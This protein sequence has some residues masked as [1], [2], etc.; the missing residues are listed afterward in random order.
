MLPQ[1]DAAFCEVCMQAKGHSVGNVPS[2]QKLNWQLFRIVFGRPVAMKN[3]VN[4]P[5]YRYGGHLELIRFKEYYR[6]LRG[7][8]HISFV[9]SSAF[10]DIFS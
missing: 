1:W 3:G 5:F 9:F 10:G 7:H 4:R 6:M 2:Q 8:E